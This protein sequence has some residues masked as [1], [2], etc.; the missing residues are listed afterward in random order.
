[1]MERPFVGPQI[2]QE[3]TIKHLPCSQWRLAMLMMSCLAAHA[4]D[5]LPSQPNT[6]T[7]DQ[8][9]RAQQHFEQI[10]SYQLRI[11]SL[12]A[13]GDK[14]L[15]RY[16]FEKSGWVRMDFTEPHPGA[17]LIYDP[18]KEKVRV[19]PFGVGTLP[20]VSLSPTNALV[21]GPNG[22]RVDQSD[23]GTLLRNIRSLQQGGKTVVFGEETL[24]GQ[25]VQHL[26]ITGSTN[27][28]VSHVHRYE[29]WLESRQE[30]PVKVVSY[31]A[32]GQI[33]ET[34]VMDAIVFN[35]RFPP[36]FFTP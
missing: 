7:A 18:A 27:A 8:I 12:S 14:V 6:S 19:W 36:D 17:V 35:L 29:I 2:K 23:M 24:S 22:H 15:M 4:A 25:T 13:Q 16:S 11:H 20:V 31:A 1:M 9:V 26:S 3:K 34:V 32:D 30:F 10:T 28:T 33:L 21:Q 5:T